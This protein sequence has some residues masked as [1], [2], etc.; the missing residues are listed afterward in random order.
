MKPYG[1]MEKANLDFLIHNIILPPKVPQER[2]DD[3]RKKDFGLLRF[4]AEVAQSYAK[5]LG[6]QGCGIEVEK[7]A[8][9]LDRMVKIHNPHLNFQS[10]I[11]AE[12]RSLKPGDAFG[13]HIV[14]QNAGITF[15][16]IGNS[17]QLE[18]FEVS[19]PQNVPVAC[20]GRLQCNYPGPTTIIPWEITEDSS[21]L[22]QMSEFLHHMTSEQFTSETLSKS[23]KG[24]NTLNETRSSPSPE[25][26]ISLFT[27][28][29][30]AVGK[31]IRPDAQV[32]TKS[33]RDECNWN[34]ANL[35]WRRSG[36][37]LVIRVALQ[38]TI[39]D[40]QYK[41]LILEVIRTL[42]DQAILR[43]HDS[44]AISCIS[45]KLARR[46]QKMKDKVPP[47]P[48][49]RIMETTERGSALLKKRWEKIAAES[50]RT[51]SWSSELS[52]TSNIAENT[53]ILLKNSLSWITKRL[54]EY[55]NPQSIATRIADPTEVERF[56]S[57]DSFPSISGNS[58]VDK[59]ISVIDFETWIQK[60]LETW[61]SQTNLNVVGTLNSKMKEYHKEAA[62]IYKD[63]NILDISRMILTIIEMWVFLDSSVCTDEPLLKEYSPEI[64]H[65]LLE[66][67]LF[68]QKSD[69]QR[70]A[71]VEKYLCKRHSE[72]TLHSSIFARYAAPNSFAARYYATSRPLQDLREKITTKATQHREAKI[73]ELKMENARYNDLKEKARNKTCDW[74]YNE[75]AGR[76]KHN[77]GCEKCRWN[78][79]ANN[80]SIIVHEWPLPCDEIEARC[81]IFE[82]QPPPDFAQWRDATYYLMMEV[83]S[84]D[85]AAKAGEG[86]SYRFNNWE[87]LH[88]NETCQD[89]RITWASRTKPIS[90]RSHYKRRD[91]LAVESDVVVNHAG[92]FRLYDSKDSGWV[93]SQHRTCTTKPLCNS[94]IHDGTYRDLSYAVNDVLHTHN[95]NIARQFEC[96][97]SLTLREYDAF[98]GLRSGYSLQWHNILME[99]HKRDLTFNK[100]AVYLLIL[101]AACHLGLTSGLDGWCRESHTT[102][103]E[104]GFSRQ[105]I[106]CLQKSLSIVKSNWEQAV[107]LKTLI[108]LARRLISCGHSS[109]KS[110]TLAFLREARQVCNPWIESIKKKI[111]EAQEESK[112]KDLRKWLLRLAGIQ[113]ST[114]DV[115]QTFLS[116]IFEEP[117]DV[118]DYLVCLN[119]IYDNS[120]GVFR[121]LPRDIELLLEQNRRFSVV[122]ES[123]IEEKLRSDEGGDILTS[124]TKRILTKRA[125]SGT[126]E[127]VTTPASR[128]WALRP[129]APA[130]ESGTVVHL[131]VL[132][133]K[134]LVN[135]K[136]NGR[137]PSEYFTHEIYKRLLGN[138]VLDVV[139]S[140][141][142]GVSYETKGLF[143]GLK[144]HFHLEAGD[145]TIRKHLPTLN[146]QELA[147]HEFIPLKY[148]IGD[149]PI[150]I[151]QGGTQ[152]LDFRSKKIIFYQQP[153]W[154]NEADPSEDWILELVH[155]DFNGR[156]MR[157]NGHYLLDLNR[158]I[159]QSITEI[160]SPIEDRNYIVATKTDGSLVNFF[161]PRYKL[162]FFLNESDS[163]E[164]RSI[165]GL[166][167]DQNQNIGTL[168]GL[169]SFL[170]LRPNGKASAQECILLPYGNIMT[171]EAKSGHASVCIEAPESDRS[172]AVYH[173]DRVM[174]KLLDDGT[175]KARYTRL[176]LHAVCG[177]ILPDPLTGRTGVAEALD[178]LRSAASFS[179]QTLQN[180]EAALL[181]LIAKLTPNRSFYPPGRELMQQVGWAE[182]LPVWVQNDNFYPL[183][184]EIFEDWSSR[185]FLID[186]SI[187][188]KTPECGSI[189]LLSRARYH[190]SVFDEGDIEKKNRISH[191]YS[192]QLRHT[193]NSKE[194]EV[195][196]I[197]KDI[198]EWS[199]FNDLE[200]NLAETLM[201]LEKLRGA[202]ASFAPSYTPEVYAC[203]PIENWCD[204]YNWCQNCTKKDRFYLLFTFGSWI[205]RS[206]VSKKILKAFITIAAIE[207]PYDIQVPSYELFQPQIGLYPDRSFI[208][209][210]FYD[211]IITFWDSKYSS[212]SC[213]E[214]PKY[215]WESHHDHS[216]RK[217]QYYEDELTR[218]RSAAVD[219]IMNQSKSDKPGNPRGR[220]DLLRVTS[221]MQ[222]IRS[223]FE[224]CRQN[225]EL[226]GYLTTLGNRLKSFTAA[227]ESLPT[228]DTSTILQ[229]PLGEKL[230]ENRLSCSISLEELLNNREAPN[231][232]T[233]QQLRN[234]KITEGFFENLMQH[235]VIMSNDNED[236]ITP[237]ILKLKA[238]TKPFAQKYGD[239]LLE[240][241]QALKQSV[242]VGSFDMKLTLIDYLSRWTLWYQNHTAMCLETLLGT[243][244]R[245]LSPH[246]IYEQLL[247]AA[248]LW[249]TSTILDIIQ[250]LRLNRRK[251]LYPEWLKVFICFG[252]AITWLQRSNRLCRFAINGA[253][254]EIEKD[255]HGFRRQHWKAEDYVDW[256]LFEIDSEMM[257]RPIQAKIGQEMM[258]EGS[259]GNVVM[260]LNMGEGKSAVIMPVVTAAL[261]DT[262]RLVRPIVLKPLSTQMFQI[263]AQRLSGLCDR[264]IYFL[265]FNRGLKIGADDVGKIF[266]LYKRCKSNGDILLTLPEHLLSFKLMGMEKLLQGNREFADVLISA[267][268]WLDE[269]TRDVLDESDEILHIRYQLIYTMGKQQALEGDQDRWTLIQDFLEYLQECATEWSENYPTAIEV[270]PPKA[271]KGPTALEALPTN[272]AE[273]PTALEVLPTKEAKYPTIR[274]ISQEV[275]KEMLESMAKE[276][277]IDGTTRMPTLSSKLRLLHTGLRQK[278]F[279]F[280]TVRNISKDL[281]GTVLQ[282]CKH[283]KIQ[284]LVLRGLI[285]DGVLFFILR[286]KRYRVDYGL[287]TKRSK[288]AVPYRAKDRP[289]VKAE[290]GH[291]EVVLTLTCLTYYYGG[292]ED[293]DLES[294]FELL[295]KTDDPD[296]T[297]ER[298]TSWAEK[299]DAVKPNLSRLQ[300]LNLLD[301]EQKKS[302][303]FPFFKY[304]KYVIDFFLSELIFPREAKGF[305]HKLS[306]SGWDIAREK[307][308]N[309]TGFSGTNDNRYLLPTSIKQLDLKEQMHTNSLVLMNLLR[310]E[311][312]TVIKVH[313]NGKRLTASEMLREIV[314]LDPKVRVL[315][316]VGAQILE[317]DNYGVAREWLKLEESSHI[318]GAVFF[319]EDDELLVL[320][321]D[322]KIEPF[323]SSNL[324]K[325]L[326]QALVYLDEAHT[327]GTDLKLPVDTRAAVTLG[328]NLAKD[329]FVQGCMRMRKLG[330][331]HSLVFLAP[332]D[333]YSHIQH[334][335]ERLETENAGVSDVLLWTMQE[336]CRQIQHGFAIWADQGFQYLK[337]SQGWNDFRAD[338]DIGALESAIQEPESRP[339]LEMYGADD[340]SLK[341]DHCVLNS[342]N[343]KEITRQLDE[344]NVI[345]TNSVRVQEEQEREVDHEVEEERNIERPKPAKAMQHQLAD[346]LRTLVRS[347]RFHL[348]SSVFRPPFS[349]FARVTNMDDY[350]RPV[351]WILEFPHNGQPYLVFISPYEANELMVDIKG[352]RFVRLHCYAPRVSRGMSNFE[353]FSICPVQQLLNTNPKLPLDVYSRIRLN[354]FAGQLFFENEQ[355]YQDLCRYLS[356]D[357]DAQRISGHEGNDGWVSNTD[358][359]GVS[360]LPFKQSPI[361][362]LKAITKMRRK[363]QGFASTHLGG[364]LDSLVLRKDDFTSRSKA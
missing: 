185:Q 248:G 352:S 113:L 229:D 117:T 33:I 210:A 171:Y 221:A 239:D 106:D 234:D 60:N 16:R 156:R 80:M 45:K 342:P 181:K 74:Y 264:R 312:N 209:T 208:D 252:E 25:Y 330:N 270:L 138:T 343:G 145:L 41:L 130:K 338:G 119:I 348:N 340:G 99:L 211:S 98:T 259:T 67:L 46:C 3:L 313:D 111:Q 335:T 324:S 363:G 135:G 134:I 267:Q 88:Q 201:N 337:R 83:C 320:K 307:S 289:A 199:Q 281:Q 116:E 305:P 290:F 341:V 131:N 332:P 54:R 84:I 94:Q 203:D 172:Y 1:N 64:P 202:D 8:N 56:L 39:S 296:L 164:C 150:T 357:Y 17:L 310:K 346:Q 238:S 309:T 247:E 65:N 20:K 22:D 355:Y 187:Q 273:G 105:L 322:G 158:N 315:L 149:I 124:T 236:P 10:Q 82:L 108:L 44:Y 2:P 227:K 37:W 361:P 228:F 51:I 216:R 328:P 250:Q 100:D 70:V 91:I 11:R 81:V 68:I 153:K 77:R 103:S 246:T 242:P 272:E 122:A 87:S 159:H 161:L 55:E 189:D 200:S 183:A 230:P 58:E 274:I 97:S 4:V 306:T 298:W 325:Q 220:Y 50:S 261:A 148:F 30:R 139:A 180:T 331:G 90:G 21:F 146:K 333:I 223:R 329:K 283:L 244:K 53:G 205:Y 314:G 241:V 52:T 184:A 142:P 222:T 168:I 42:L 34:N 266:E 18:T 339:L 157:R 225:R 32:I 66:P 71:E 293:S 192:H 206:A 114:F 327:R 311:N 165:R 294:C 336:G 253:L 349:I 48:L 163:I 62:K 256:L 115:D 212:A 89:Y 262:T 219:E 251:A 104:E 143:C 14:E 96:P 326:D 271:A 110:D 5:S 303:I 323:V 224:I 102:L 319:G 316:D 191:S 356:L 43:N 78:K 47:A 207:S 61:C 126:W 15:R 304:N 226:H 132:E 7:A 86:E 347:G 179:F 214:V 6:N 204:L 29:M 175:L 36:M 136:P 240:S 269:N 141:K 317:L 174:N 63:H 280:I 197:S 151:L 182:N 299:C 295:L 351:R 249:P 85:S 217:K 27:G 167:V 258:R 257:I 107:T 291:P 186:N 231:L 190:N 169:K 188:F 49:A 28:M 353:Y 38:T 57:P 301:E 195:Y 13:V 277:C 92:Q 286:D 218:Q 128:W 254:Q 193:P 173:I 288:L 345:V 118:T 154:W 243:L 31:E 40:E 265:P 101:H 19:T 275:G 152:W 93:E 213:S 198:V 282:E 354:L 302:E 35:P 268:D 121:G 178:G 321:R 362:F 26:I 255:V 358:A 235:M 73:K 59:A 112:I 75:S 166:I 263:L 359:D 284:L 279:E 237:I 297:Y 109:V 292:L 364:L 69:M 300:G 79:E 12:V 137:L 287:D 9:A 127:Q 334:E 245:A 155:P 233:F 276:L 120:L 285:A 24:G 196:D 194:A 344:F 144:L 232:F 278:V 260:Q 133:G 308:N 95:E 147:E 177:G 318:H 123:F 350:L 215:A 176:Y 160:L 360:V 162:D 23:R 129:F 72:S 76:Y 140:E 170:K 125:I